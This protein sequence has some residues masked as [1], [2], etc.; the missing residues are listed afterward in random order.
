MA[1]R[2]RQLLVPLGFRFHPTEEE[3][4]YYYLRKKVSFEA[5]DLDVIR[6]INARSA[7][8]FKT[9]GIASAILPQGQEISNQNSNKQ[10]NHIWFLEGYRER[11]RIFL[12][13]IETSI[14]WRQL[15]TVAARSD[16]LLA[17]QP[18]SIEHQHS[19]TKCNPVLQLDVG[20]SS[21]KVPF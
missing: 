5:I 4:L 3:L 21:Q 1:A 15:W 13:I 7:L 9:I 2:N 12:K 10:G 19:Q 6:E 17:Q 18:Q 20:T 8:V 16:Q 11:Y 14:N